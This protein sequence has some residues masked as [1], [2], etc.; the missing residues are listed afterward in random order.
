MSKLTKQGVRDLNTGTS[1]GHV[2]RYA[3]QTHTN[4]R[5]GQQV[6][7]MVCY[8]GDVRADIEEKNVEIRPRLVSYRDV[9]E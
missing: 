3:P 4:A 7:S 1:R 6:T 8:C 9:Y 2:H 5:N